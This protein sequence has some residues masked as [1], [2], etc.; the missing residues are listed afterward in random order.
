METTTLILII[1]AV[2]LGILY[3]VRRNARTK[4]STQ[5]RRR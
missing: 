3:F 2:V 4:K 1:L 5:A